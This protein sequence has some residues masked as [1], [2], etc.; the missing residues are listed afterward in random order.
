MPQG[1]GPDKSGEGSELRW[2][3]KGNEI[4][5][6]SSDGEVIRTSFTVDPT[7]RPKQIDLTFLSGTHKGETCSGIYHRGD[8]D[9]NILWVCI[10]DPGSKTARPTT[11]SYQFGEGRSLLSLYPFESSTATPSDASQKP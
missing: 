5:W 1:K 9:E 11:F 10:A 2:L 6:T 8:L 3:V 7:K 4:T